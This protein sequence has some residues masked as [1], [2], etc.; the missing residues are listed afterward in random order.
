MN[1]QEVA[2]LLRDICDYSNIRVV[3][4]TLEENGVHALSPETEPDFYAEDE[5]ER[6]SEEFHLNEKDL[7]TDFTRDVKS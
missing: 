6:Y 1:W 2:K 4:Y 7:E 5:I 3:F